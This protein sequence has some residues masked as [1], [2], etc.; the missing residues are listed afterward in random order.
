LVVWSLIYH[1]DFREGHAPN[2]NGWG[3]IKLVP[4]GLQLSPD[5][6]YAG[7]YFFLVKH[8]PEFMLE[9]KVKMVTQTEPNLIVQLLTRD[10]PEVNSESAV[11]LIYGINQGSVRHMIYKHDFLLEAFSIGFP[12]ELDRWYELRLSFYEGVFKYHIDGVEKYKRNGKLPKNNTYTEPHIAVFKGTAVFQEVKVYEPAIPPPPVSPLTQLA[13]AIPSAYIIR[14]L[15]V[16]HLKKLFAEII[17]RPL[18]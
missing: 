16:P 6:E 11:S 3:G 7:V 10:G 9:T 5:K 2:W 4:E 8:K 15:L 14:D 12:V 13:I 1:H 18:E 17:R